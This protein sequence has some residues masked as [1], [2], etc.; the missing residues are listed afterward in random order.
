MQSPSR[1]LLFTGP[2]SVWGI[3]LLFFIA[4]NIAGCSSAP[5]KPSRS[6]TNLSFGTSGKPSTQQAALSRHYKA[7]KNAPYKL[8]GLSKSGVDCSGFVHITYRD[9]FKRKLPRSTALLAKTGNSVTQK[10]LKFGDLVFFKTGRSKRHVG[11]YIN[12]GKFIHASSSRGVM[13]S[14]LK[15]NYWSKSYW[16]AKRVL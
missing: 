15:S 2:C 8:G 9:I 13:Q 14:S 10:S 3:A 6:S 4:L 12:N 1:H 7:W 11:I 5:S 16:M